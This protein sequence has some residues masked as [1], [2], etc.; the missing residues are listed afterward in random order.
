MPASELTDAF[1]NL[2]WANENIIKAQEAFND[3]LASEPYRIVTQM[4]NKRGK[5]VKK[6]ILDTFPWQFPFMARDVAHAIR[7][8]LDML[9]VQLAIKNHQPPERV[10][11]PVRK[12]KTAFYSS[13]SYG[14]IEATFGVD[15]AKWFARQQ[16]YFGG[17]DLVWSIHEIDRMDKH[18]ELVPVA[19]QSQGVMGPIVIGPAG[20][21]GKIH[22]ITIGPTDGFDPADNSVILIAYDPRDAA[23]IQGEGKPNLLI[24]FANIA[25]IKGKHIPIFLAEAAGRV[26]SILKDAEQFF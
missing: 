19:A 10:Y 6:A 20:F 23:A 7:V 2:K 18:T 13:G 14:T 22:S 1:A 9:A 25:P 21:S 26:E 11:Y 15:V 16:P 24:A 5:M 17:D 4:D 8:P 12:D 3:F